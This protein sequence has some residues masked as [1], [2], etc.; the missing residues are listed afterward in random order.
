M[1][2]YPLLLAERSAA[3][4]PCA[5]DRSFSLAMWRPALAGPHEVRL[6]ADTA[7]LRLEAV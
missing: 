3:L 6:K 7:R 2:T 1:V 4:K 5:R